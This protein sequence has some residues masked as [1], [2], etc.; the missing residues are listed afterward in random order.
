MLPRVLH[1]K[2]YGRRHRLCCPMSFPVIR[3]RCSEGTECNALRAGHQHSPTQ[4]PSKTAETNLKMCN[5]AMSAS[6]F[7][8]P[9]AVRC[10]L[11]CWKRCMFASTLSY[12]T[13]QCKV[14]CD[15]DKLYGSRSTKMDKRGLKTVPTTTMLYCLTLSCWYGTV[16]LVENDH[17]TKL[18]T[19]VDKRIG[20]QPI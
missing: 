6:G 10:I 11:Y 15:C 14:S 3:I 7:A 13:L 1:D 19:A 2:K 17:E 9:R 18:P 12:H 20:M 8:R 4:W 16:F 5:M